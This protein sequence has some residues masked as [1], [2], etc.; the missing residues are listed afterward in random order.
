[1]HRYELVNWPQDIYLF[2]GEYGPTESGESHGVPTLLT[3]VGEDLI[4]TGAAIERLLADGW[5]LTVLND[6]RDRY[7]YQLHKE[8][9]YHT[10]RH[11]SHLEEVLGDDVHE[12]TLEVDGRR[13]PYS[14]PRPTRT[15]RAASR[16]EDHLPKSGF[17]DI[18]LRASYRLADRDKAETDYAFLAANGWTMDRAHQE[19][20][21]RGHRDVKEA[22]VFL[23]SLK[24]TQWEMAPDPKASL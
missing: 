14:R 9:L 15:I 19:V 7:G 10:Q 16:K 6:G 11:V 8:Q 13:S 5:T 24:L 18:M 2:D 12:W 1:M 22:R 4:R 21:A 23:K 3:A 17:A 20:I